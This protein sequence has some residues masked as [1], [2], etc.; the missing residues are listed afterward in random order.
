LAVVGGGCVFG[1]AKNCAATAVREDTF[2]LHVPVPVQEPPQRRNV[3]PF[4]GS[5]VRSTLVPAANVAVHF[6]GQA[7]PAGWLVTPPL[8]RMTTTNVGGVAATAGIAAPNKDAAATATPAKHLVARRR[9]RERT[10]V[11]SLKC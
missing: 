1:P 10:R 9:P 2:T 6:P 5:G 11:A 8:S 4:F 7:I 3:E